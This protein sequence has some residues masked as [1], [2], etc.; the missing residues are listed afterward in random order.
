M[1]EAARPVKRDV[2]RAF[3]RAAATYDEAAV[4][5]REVCSRLLE[6]LDP[7]RLSPARVVDLG[8][9]TG[10][11]F[12]P[13]A[14]RYPAASI[15]GIDLATAMLAKARLREPW[16]R[17][18]AG[19]NG[20]ALA[21]ADAERLPLAGG[22][23]Q[24]VFSSLALQWCDAPAVFREVSRVLEPGGLFLFAT[25]GPDTLKELRAAF[26]RADSAPHVN[27]FADMHDLG[28]ALGQAGLADPVMEMETITLEYDTVVAIA[29]D[30]KAIGAVNTLPS[31]AKGLP[32]RA[33]WGRMTEAY[34]RLRRNGSLPATYEVVYGH[35]WKVPPRTT[36]DGHPVIA[37]APRR[38]R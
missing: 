21:C 8:C 3:D 29:R 17:R 23:A 2:R 36:A 7:V 4:L 18:I 33:R 37:F 20:P 15:V 12:A 19:R 28:D 27:A 22:S 10:Q 26:A 32:G 16:W 9:G 11:A 6:H 5:Q 24:L 14:K 31:R 1:A 30:L 13:L 35:A 25:F 38:P 34:E